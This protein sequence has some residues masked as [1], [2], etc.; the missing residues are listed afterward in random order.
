MPTATGPSPTQDGIIS[1]CTRYYKA[2]SGDSCSKIASSYGTFSLDDFLSWNPAVGQDCS[3]LWLGHYYCIGTLSCTFFLDHSKLLTSFHWRTGV[4]G[5]PT[6]KPTTTAKPPATTTAAGCADAPSPTQPGA[7][8]PC[9][10]WHEVGS[11]NSCQS[12]EKEYGISA[13]N[14]NAW[15]PQVGSDC[16]TLW[17]GYYVCVGV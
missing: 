11:G 14:F 12:I 17:L 5:T 13:A 1:T 2:V 10:T 9:R 6:A 4:P 7:V 15:N 8:C 3:G 16:S